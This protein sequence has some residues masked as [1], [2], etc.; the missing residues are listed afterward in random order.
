[1]ET[2]IREA[3]AFLAPKGLLAL[4][5]GIGQHEY[6]VSLAAQVGLAVHGRMRDLSGRPRMLLFRKHC[7]RA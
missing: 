6:L 2:I 5:T 4:E 3:P 1:L 7:P